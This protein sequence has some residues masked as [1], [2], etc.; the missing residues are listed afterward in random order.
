MN[1]KNMYKTHYNMLHQ[2]LI[3][4]EQYTVH[5]LIKISLP[6][7]LFQSLSKKIAY[8]ECIIIHLESKVRKMQCRG[9][10]RR[11]RVVLP[12]FYWIN[13]SILSNTCGV[14]H[15]LL[16]NLHRPFAPWGSVAKWNTADY[17]SQWTWNA[18]YFFYYTFCTTTFIIYVRKS[19][20]TIKLL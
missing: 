6:L 8:N 10:C 1:I 5:P 15:L 9:K 13:K 7:L 20:K 19:T 14:V 2:Y 4:I 16:N 17:C 3:T 18:R 11:A 12:A